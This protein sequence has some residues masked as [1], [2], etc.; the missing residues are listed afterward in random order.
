ANE[1]SNSYVEQYEFMI[2]NVGRGP[3]LR[4]T[5]GINNNGDNDAFFADEYPHSYGLSSAE[6]CKTR[7]DKFRIEQMHSQTIKDEQ[8]RHFYLFYFDQLGEKYITTVE[9]KKRVADVKKDA[10]EFYVVMENIREK[11]K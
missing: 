10:P 11:I 2:K 1:D 3:A 8:R 4:I 6:S 9:I 7:I 5:G